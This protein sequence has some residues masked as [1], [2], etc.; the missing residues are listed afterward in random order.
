MHRRTF[1]QGL[2]AS[3]ALPFLDAMVPAGRLRASV[4]H[5]ADP[6]RLV[7]IELVHGAAGCNEWG[8]TQNLWAP[9]AVGRDFDLAPSAL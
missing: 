3:V 7:A 1:L 4:G 2:G 5:A 6:T 9:E 8:A